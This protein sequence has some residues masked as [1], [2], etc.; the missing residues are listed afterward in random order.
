VGMKK[1]KILVE[2]GADAKVVFRG[3]IIEVKKIS[4]HESEL[5]F[6][7]NLN[8]EE[9]VRYLEAFGIIKRKEVKTNKSAEK[10][11]DIHEFSN[12]VIER[13]IELLEKENDLYVDAKETTEHTEN[14]TEE[15]KYSATT[16]KRKRKS[17]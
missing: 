5:T 11:N 9:L 6:P 14:T 15:E 13:Q 16:K 12:K 4:E 1:Q 17:Q 8:Y 3:V 7:E 10:N 2:K